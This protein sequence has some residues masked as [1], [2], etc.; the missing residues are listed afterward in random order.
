M[1]VVHKH[2]LVRARVKEP[3]KS[4]DEMVSWLESL[5]KKIKMKT[6]HGPIASYI[7]K[8][9]NRGMTGFV[10]IETSHIACHIWDEIE[11]ALIQL[12][13][14]SCAEYAEEVVIR[15]VKSMEVVEHEYMTVDRSSTLHA[16]HMFCEYSIE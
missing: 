16:G 2:L 9:G 3:I 15:A 12:D 7:T 11:P 13:V 4:E 6:V 1:S 5:V 10:M 8:E 14:Y